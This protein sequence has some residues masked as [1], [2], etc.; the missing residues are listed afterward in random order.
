LFKYYFVTYLVTICNSYNY[1][2]PFS[3]FPQ[4]WPLAIAGRGEAY[5]PL[6]RSAQRHPQR[7]QPLRAVG[8]LLQNVDVLFA[9]PIINVRQVDAV[10][11][12]PYLTAKRCV[13]RLVEMGLLREITGQARNQ[14]YCADEILRAIDATLK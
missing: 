11:Q 7:L 1:S 5:R 4:V 14:L 12:V 10:L 3:K 8:R 9:R 2:T 13:E 6:A